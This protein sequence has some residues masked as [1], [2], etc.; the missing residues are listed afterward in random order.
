[1]VTGCRAARGQQKRQSGDPENQRADPEHEIKRERA[2]ESHGRWLA[3]ALSEAL[4]A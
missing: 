3:A 4:S 1:M 2:G